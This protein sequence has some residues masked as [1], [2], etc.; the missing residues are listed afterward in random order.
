MSGIMI[1]AAGICV[2]AL[3]G[4]SIWRVCEERKIVQVKKEE[5]VLKNSGK[6]PYGKWI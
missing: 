5:E 6:N 4:A 3:C 1:S 2:A